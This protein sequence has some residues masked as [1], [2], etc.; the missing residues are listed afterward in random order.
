MFKVF[1]WPGQDCSIVSGYRRWE[2]EFIHPLEEGNVEDS[3]KENKHSVVEETCFLTFQQE[4]VDWRKETSGGKKVIVSEDKEVRWICLLLS[5]S[6]CR[7][8]ILYVFLEK[9][10][11]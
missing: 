3:W 6:M 1:K 4:M 10:N 7:L 9:C 2:K 8:R 5:Y 11:D